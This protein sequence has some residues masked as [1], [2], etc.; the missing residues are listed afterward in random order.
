MDFQRL[1]E[2]PAGFDSLREEAEREGY[3]FLDRLVERWSGDAYRE[4]RQ[5]TLW[6]MVTAHAIQAIGAQTE[7]EYDPSPAHR[8]IRHFYVAP[9]FRRS[10]VGRTL[11]RHL[12]DHALNL[13][14][15]LHLRAT[16]ALSTAF[17]DALGFQ[18]VQRADR[19][20]ELV[21]A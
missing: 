7:D 4:D 19:S 21:R 10:G 2:L 9:S 11:A 20:H 8:R 14:P 5:A 3:R 16:H 6:A 1:I 18:R 17:W 13:A 15:R 12:I